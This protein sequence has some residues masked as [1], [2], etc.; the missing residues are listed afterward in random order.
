MRFPTMHDMGSHGLDYDA[1]TA[2]SLVLAAM[3]LG[4]IFFAMGLIGVAVLL[5]FLY[6]AGQLGASSPPPV[7]ISA[8]FLGIIVLIFFPIA[9]VWVLLDFFLIYK[10]ISRG[11]ISS[12]EDPALILGIIQIA[13]GGFIT[14]VLLIIAW[15]KIRDSIA[16]SSGR[17]GN[18]EF[19]VKF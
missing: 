12:A 4:V 13:V 6:T 11:K 3:I 16:N 7:A 10:P 19:K 9:I 17:T 5:T 8:S 2:K 15:V 1:S 14:G 18:T